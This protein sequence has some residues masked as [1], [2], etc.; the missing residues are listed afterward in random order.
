MKY[1]DETEIRKTI[2]I[3][4]PGNQ[5]FEIRIHYNSK[6]ILSGYFKDADTAIKQLSN[7]NLK[8]CNVYMSLNELNPQCYGRSQKNE[9]C[10]VE[11]TTSDNNIVGIDWLM[12]DLDPNRPKGTSSS[13]SQFDEAVKLA[14]KVFKYMSDLGFNKPIVAKSGNGVH[15]LYRVNL[16]N[17]DNT[18]TIIQN[19]LGTLDAFFSYGEKFV[20]GVGVDVSTHNQSRVCKLYGTLAQKGSNSEEYPHRMSKLVFIPEEIKVNDISYLQKLVNAIPKEPEKSKSYNNYN[21]RNFDLDDWLDKFGIRYKKTSYSGGDKYI[22]DHCVFDPEHSGKDAAIFK[23]KD[24][25]IGYHCFHSS[26]AGKKWQDVR[27][28]YEPDAYEKKY[29]EREKMMYKSFNRNQKKES[30]EIVEKENE[31]LFYSL[32]SILAIPKQEE[33]FV[34]TGIDDIDKKLRGLKKGF[35]S[36]WSGLRASS[37]STAL[38]CIC[39]DAC[40][41]GNNVGFFSGE[42]APVNFANWLTQQAAGKKY[43]KPTGYE[44]Y[45][46]VPFETKKLIAKW[47]DSRFWLFNNNYGNDA[48]AIL[49]QFEKAIVDKKLDLVILDNLMSFDISVM[50]MDKYEAQ[51]N[52]VWELHNLAQKYNVHI[53]FVAH[54]RK[55]IGFLRLDDISGSADIQN[56]VEYAFIVHRVNNDFKRLSKQMFGWKDDKEI[57]ESTNVIEIC[58]DRDGGIQ[59]YFIPLWYEVESKR[60]K[61]YKSENKIYG[62]CKDDGMQYEFEKLDLGE[63]IP[64][65]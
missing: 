57:Y 29:Q 16:A 47:L 38:S 45:Y 10:Q 24:G 6:K 42:L 65:D 21:A 50:S 31:P 14:D 26:C 44:G 30:I 2:E 28:M 46:S 8:D 39:L 13:N 35:V 55:A 62:W 32:E 7:V 40:N 3:L 25:C 9:L 33:T 56:A 4:K 5:L 37:K 58:K 54:P 59:D 22:L 15:L 19:C 53:A 49:N 20:S 18:K 11:T 41:N 36:V 63:E 43:V 51:K 60:L 27:L 61:N 64:F 52:F 12:I 1:F 34:K 48:K 17:N 23:S